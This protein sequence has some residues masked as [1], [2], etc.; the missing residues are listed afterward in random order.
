[1]LLTMHDARTRLAQEVEAEVRRHFPT[2]V[3]D[4]VIPRNVRVSE[5]PSY[6][7]PIT[8][9]DP[10]S[11]GAGAYFRLAMEVVERG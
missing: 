2:L 6:G 10:R 3:F 1:M 8:H 11:T 4:T 5:A 7:L 9:Y